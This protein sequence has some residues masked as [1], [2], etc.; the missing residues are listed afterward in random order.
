MTDRPRIA[1]ITAAEETNGNIGDLFIEL[2][3]RRLLGSSHDIV[4]VPSRRN[5]SDEEIAELNGCDATLLCGTNLYQDAWQSAYDPSVMDRL[6]CPVVPFGV[7]GS[8]AEMDDLHVGATTREM[9]ER[10][11][12]SCIAGSVRDHFSADVVR[13]VG[14]DN[15]IL[16]G[17]PVL[18]WA[19]RDRLPVPDG[20]RPKRVVVTARNWLMHRWPDVSVDH[21]VQ[22]A[23]LRE[24]LDGLAGEE[25]VF[26]IHE[27]FDRSLVDILEIPADRV[28]ES[29]EVAEYL[30]LYTDP[31]NVVLAN[32]LHAG[33]LAVANGVPAVFVGHDTRTYAFCEMLGLDCVELFAA[34][35][36]Q[37][38]LAALRRAL[39]GLPD[40]ALEA[41]GTAFRVLHA[42]M[43]SFMALNGLV[44][45]SRQD[46]DAR[47]ALLRA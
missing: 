46:E 23:F 28:F 44:P 37:A 14:V 40:P 24:V 36:A 7:G 39:A 34:D 33:M 6:T 47:A 27:D 19:G 13:N 38:S 4:T 31:D 12:A 9:I 32:R 16:T 35:A 1:L 8:A 3:V 10:L 2:A 45:P 26:A 5:P 42:A 17:C 25:I 18:F 21:P 11:H 43:G 22:I 15:A 20:R 30:A 41:A 29:T